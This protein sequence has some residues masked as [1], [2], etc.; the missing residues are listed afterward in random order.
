MASLEGWGL[1]PA[2]LLVSIKSDA[3]RAFRVPQRGRPVGAAALRC[4]SLSGQ[5]SAAARG[6]SAAP[7]RPEERSLMASPSGTAEPVVVGR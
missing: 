7:A 6:D 3:C 2:S 1:L 5:S 4:R